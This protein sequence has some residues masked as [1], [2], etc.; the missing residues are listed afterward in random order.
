[1]PY[2]KFNHPI[3]STWRQAGGDVGNKGDEGVGGDREDGGVGEDEKLIVLSK[4]R[5]HTFGV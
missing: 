2:Q 4:Y 3:I 5:S 1:M